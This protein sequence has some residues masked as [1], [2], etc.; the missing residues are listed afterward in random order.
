LTITDRSVSEPLLRFLVRL[1]HDGQSRGCY[2][3]VRAAFVSRSASSINRALLPDH[4]GQKRTAPGMLSG[5]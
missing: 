3:L 2:R 5:E 4:C 1:Q